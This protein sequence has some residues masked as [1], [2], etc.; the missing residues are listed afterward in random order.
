MTFG[1]DSAFPITCHIGVSPGAQAGEGTSRLYLANIL[2]SAAGSLG[3]GFFLMD[4]LSLR[5]ISIA[6]AYLGILVCGWLLLRPAPAQNRSKRYSYRRPYSRMDAPLDPPPRA[7][8]QYRDSWS[9][10]NKLP[11][12]PS[13]AL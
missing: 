9:V 2:G 3:T 7:R 12:A 5:W 6:L 8:F 13:S 11:P 4:V 10:P 1:S